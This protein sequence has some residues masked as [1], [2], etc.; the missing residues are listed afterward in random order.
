M[1]ASPPQIRHGDLATRA[2]SQARERAMSLPQTLRS[3]VDVEYRQYRLSA[4]IHDC[5]FT[6]V[7]GFDAASIVCAAIFFD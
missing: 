4:K 2:N 3:G 1:P 5:V 7:I 6:A